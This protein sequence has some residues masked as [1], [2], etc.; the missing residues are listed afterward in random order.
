MKKPELLEISEAE[1]EDVQKRLAKGELA[2]TDL[3]IIKAV[4]D[5]MLHLRQLLDQKNTA[6][7]RVLRMIFGAKTE[8][9]SS[10]LNKKKPQKKKKKKRKG[11]GRRGTDEYWGAERKSVPH[12]SLHPG[13][14]C[15]DC[16]KGKL[17]DTKRPGQ[18]LR[19][20]AQ[21]PVTG[22]IYKQQKLRCN[23]CGKLFSAALPE[24]AGQEKYDSTVGTMLPLLRYGYGMPM[25]RLGQLQEDIGI[26]LPPGSQWEIYNP[27][28]KELQPALDEFIRQAATGELIYNDDTT[29]RILSLEKEI[30][31]EKPEPG[32]KQRTGLFTTGIISKTDNAH[33]ALF[34]SGRQH[35]G[36]N[37]Q[38]LLDQRPSGLSP[39]TQMCDGLKHNKPKLSDTDMSNCSSHGRRGFVD[40]VNSFPDECTYVLETIRQLYINDSHTKEMT[41]EERLQYHQQHTSGMM[42]DFRKWMDHKMANKDVEPSSSLGKAIN[43]IRTR[44]KQ[45]TLFLRKPGVPL[46][47]NICERALKMAIRHRNNSLFY[48]TENGAHVGDLYM[49]IIHTCRLCKI[50]PYEYLNALHQHADLLRADPAKWMPW[51]YKD[52]LAELNPA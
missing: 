3:R 49:S 26:P 6:I 32:E 37:L 12:E 30:K 36:E 41:P 46:D 18:I 33:I 5:T 23:A 9:T 38:D 39:P 4:I 50:S 1:L 17:Y 31:E 11:H 35:A 20:Y 16:P 43:Y 22:S 10:V 28:A 48:K 27:R 19:L 40:I 52:T 34:F 7:N 47:N 51:N 42:D 14:Q 21:P 25:N 2:E 24:E 45:F 15:P 44:W 29:V 13:D 8:K